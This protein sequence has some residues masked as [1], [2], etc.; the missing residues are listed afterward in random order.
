MKVNNDYFYSY[1]KKDKVHYIMCEPENQDVRAIF[2]I[3]HG[4][5]EHAARYL[6]FA[7]YLCS[8]GF[9]VYIHEHVGHGKT[10]GLVDNLGIFID[11]HQDETMLEDTLKMNITAKRKYPYLNTYLF[12]HSMGSFIVRRFA[13]KYPEHID[14]LIICGTGGKN[15][16]LGLGQNMAKLCRLFNGGNHKSKF[17]DKMAFGNFN[18]KYENVNTKFDWLSRNKEEV[19]KYID[20]DYCGYLFDVNGMISLM[21]LNKKANLDATY[22]HTSKD[23]RILIISGSMD[24]VGNYGQG[25]KEVYD[26]YKTFGCEN[27]YMKLYNSARHEL[28]NEYDKKQ[29]YEDIKNFLD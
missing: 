17:L 8:N 9:V 27:V 2:Q 1:N 18:G 15:K 4:M 24:P 19:Q 20:D 23:L 16:I 6:D 5:A 14:G 25:V 22:I 28:L 26:R 13:A 3:V 7:E 12:G 11:P 10:A 29:V 21:N